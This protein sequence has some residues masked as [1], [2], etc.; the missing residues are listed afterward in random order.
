MLSY[1]RRTKITPPFVLNLSLP[2]QIS[3]SSFTT[4]S[5]LPLP[6]HT[7]S[8]VS[9]P[10]ALPLR[11][12]PIY[13]ISANTPPQTPFLSS[14]NIANLTQNPTT[15][16]RPS[17][18]YN[19]LILATKT[20]FPYADYPRYIK[21]HPKGPRSGLILSFFRYQKFPQNHAAGLP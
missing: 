6:L 4:P 10:R 20:I 16:Y 15:P 13:T 1:F 18:R 3:L 8:F 2:S 7:F 19:N 14:L 11:F 9:T 12:P 21:D 17:K 5:T